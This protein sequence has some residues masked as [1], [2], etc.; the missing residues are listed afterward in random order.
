[1]F[2]IKRSRKMNKF[3][4]VLKWIFF[5]P[6]NQVIFSLV[7]TLTASILAFG[8][9]LVY[10]QKIIIILLSITVFG[11][12]LIAVLFY[13]NLLSAY[14]A[15][16]ISPNLYMYFLSITILGLRHLKM[17]FAY[18]P[19]TTYLESVTVIDTPK[20]II[21]LVT[22]VQISILVV[23]GY[24]KNISQK[25]SSHEAI[26]ILA[27]PNNDIPSFNPIEFPTLVKYDN[28]QIEDAIQKLMKTRG[29]TRQQCL[30]N[31]EQDLS[32]LEVEK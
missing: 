3:K 8:W 32:E 25:E 9:G 2:E 7:Y 12:I 15:D 20:S 10:D 18:S 1:M 14:L 23:Y 13:L 22:L 16:L 26:K 21:V 4:V 6:V 11:S 31:L 28:Q 5:L 17:V 19:T 24:F 29:M 30:V 27:M